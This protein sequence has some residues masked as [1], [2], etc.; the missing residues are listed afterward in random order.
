M[1]YGTNFMQCICIGHRES[2]ILSLQLFYY[3]LLLLASTMSLPC[4]ISAIVLTST[5]QQAYRIAQNP[6]GGKF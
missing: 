1:V 5:R 3:E 6:D 4:T 2:W